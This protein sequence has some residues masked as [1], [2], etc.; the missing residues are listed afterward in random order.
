M[1]V[2]NVMTD[3]GRCEAGFGGEE[4][5]GARRKPTAL[6][7]DWWHRSLALIPS[8]RQKDTFS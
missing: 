1:G 7:K 3:N 4:A 2:I 8:A 5:R 6:R